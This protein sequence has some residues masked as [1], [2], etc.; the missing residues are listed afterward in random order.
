MKKMKT[1]QTNF[2]FLQKAEALLTSLRSLTGEPY[3]DSFPIGLLEEKIMDLI[4]ESDVIQHEQQIIDF[5]SPTAYLKL[6]R[7]GVIGKLNQPAELILGLEYSA[8]SNFNFNQFISK[9]S[10]ASFRLFLEDV[11]QSKSGKTCEIRLAA[12]GNPYLRIH[13]ISLENNQDCILTV[14][15]ITCYKQLEDELTNSRSKFLNALEI[16]YLGPWEY[17]VINDLFTFNDSFY[18]MFRTTADQVG[19]YVMSSAEYVRRFVHPD[20]SF[21]VAAETQKA[22]ESNDPAFCR[23]LEHRMLYAD[24]EVGYITVRFFIVKDE[25]GKTIKTYGVNQDV[26]ERKRIEVALRERE[27][28]FKESQRA[29]FIGSYKADFVT[30]TWESSEVLDQIF[31]IDEQ[32]VRSVQEGWPSLIHPDDREMMRRYLEEEVIL[33]C[34]PFNREYRIVRK[35]DGQTRWVMGLGQ[36]ITGED[37]KVI[38]L[39]GTIQDVTERKLM[40]EALV[41]E[42][43]LL[44]S[45]LDNIPDAIYFKDE[46]SRFISINKAHARLF[47]LDDP[48]LAVGK[49]DIDFVNTEHTIQAFQDEQ[50]IIRTGRPIIGKEEMEIWLDREPTWVSTTK[51]PLRDTTG[52]IIGTFGISRDITEQKKAEELLKDSESALRDLN[53]TKD[54]FFSII[55]HDLRNPFSAIIGLSDILSI[56]IKEKN[57]EGIEEYSGIIQQSSQLAM[58]LLLNLLEWARSQTGRMKFQPVCFQ[59]DELIREV[60]EL[61]SNAA[62]H[63]SITIHCE[64]IPKLTVKADKAM[65]GAVLRNLIS[66]AVKYTHQGG[67]IRISI[68]HRQNEL[69]VSVRDNG[70]GI[71]RD[72]LEKLFR[73]DSNCSTMGTQNEKGTGLGLILCKE[74]VEKHHGKIWAESE[75]KKG[76]TF[77]FIIPCV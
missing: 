7:N 25:N 11:F 52:E 3:K 31:G 36:V 1:T 9:E 54:K 12:L 41:R 20:D 46:K 73:I 71:K 44:R 35:S 47:G 6:D 32:Y 69:V 72:V 18:S 67:H 16:A 59:I 49:T 34:S 2:A 56:Q 26:T 61:L 27:F 13:G 33:N 23:Q 75:P 43:Y 24:G 19:G 76:S 29:A 37:G 63:K 62:R 30:G 40:E 42:Q 15:D 53:A 28:F 57:Y 17:D 14:E 65:I 38:S 70:I 8:I 50:E 74:F 21:V 66:N 64:S 51:M 4:H 48:S 77:F 55:A 10:R 45:L 58:D 22:M 60:T 68:D 5:L 39:I